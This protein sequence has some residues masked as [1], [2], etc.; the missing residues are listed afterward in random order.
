MEDNN[1]AYTISFIAALTSM[2]MTILDKI[3]DKKTLHKLANILVFW[4]LVRVRFAR[5]KARSAKYI[6][7]Y[8]FSSQIPIK[9]VI[10]YKFLNGVDAYPDPVYHTLASEIIIDA[11]NRDWATL[12]LDFSESKPLVMPEKIVQLIKLVLNRFDSEKIVIFE[13]NY[14]LKGSQGI[15][16][17]NLTFV[18]FGSSLNEVELDKILKGTTKDTQPRIDSLKFN[19][20][21]RKKKE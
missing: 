5:A 3:S 19:F 21:R 4:T 1:M 13:P 11:R 8:K 18:P 6:E 20:Q 12:V 17:V 9:K 2:L 16:Y 7:G 14:G 15:N 10:T